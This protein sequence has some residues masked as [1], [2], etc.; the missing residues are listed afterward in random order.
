M[1]RNTPQSKQTTANP[2]AAKPAASPAGAPPPMKEGT[3]RLAL[4]AT[5]ATVTKGP[6]TSSLKLVRVIKA[7]PQ[8][9]YDCFVDPD[10]LAKWMP[11]HGFVGHVHKMEAKVG[12]SYKMSFS[13]INRSWTQSFGGTYRELVPGKRIRYTDQFDDPAMKG[14]MTVTIDFKAVP[15]GTELTILQEGIPAGPAADGAPYGW[16][17]SLDNLGSLCEAELPF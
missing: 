17:Q 12:G 10:A 11:P 8:R 15:G 16:S 5:A 6:K 4:G 1:A 9:V 13:T 14:E 3:T 2:A 7:P